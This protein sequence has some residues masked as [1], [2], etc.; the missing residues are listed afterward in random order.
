MDYS[1]LCAQAAALVAMTCLVG[2]PLLRTRPTILVAQLGIGLGFATHFALLGVW[3]ACAVSTL[4]AVQ[5]VTAFYA[6]QGRFAERA[7]YSLIVGMVLAGIWFWSGPVTTLSVSAMVLVA[8][9]RMQT[10]QLA[11][12]L[13]LLAGSAA[14]AA[15]DYAIGSFIALSADVMS[16]AMGT[17]MLVRLRSELSLP[18]G[19]GSTAEAA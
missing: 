5:T 17:F 11:L 12:R 14:W 4:G 1:F 10:G 7:G 15:H 19:L 9:G 6:G 2:W 3:A 16:F 8:L 18:G 13:L